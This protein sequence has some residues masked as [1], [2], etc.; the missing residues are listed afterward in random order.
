MLKVQ[1]ILKQVYRS[2]SHEFT[3]I[4]NQFIVYIININYVHCTHST[5]IVIVINAYFIKKG[6]RTQ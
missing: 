6:F 3:F 1:S 5:V 2:S 4:T